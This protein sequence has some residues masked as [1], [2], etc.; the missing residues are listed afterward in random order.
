MLFMKP[1]LRSE[2]SRAMDGWSK[3]PKA[4]MKGWRG[5]RPGRSGKIELGAILGQ[6]CVA[7]IINLCPV[8]NTDKFCYTS[9]QPDWVVEEPPA[10]FASIWGTEP[11][12][13]HV[14]A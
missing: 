4:A 13:E 3:A 14:E 8:A 10:C 2:S 6:I 12:T 11:E 1:P 5:P 9:P 7:C